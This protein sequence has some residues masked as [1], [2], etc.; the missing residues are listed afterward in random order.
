MRGG[1]ERPL[2]RSDEGSTGRCGDGKR[3]ENRLIG[4]G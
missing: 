3:K 4:G 2:C 1:R